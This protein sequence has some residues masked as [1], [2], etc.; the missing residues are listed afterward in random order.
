MREKRKAAQRKERTDEDDELREI[1]DNSGLAVVASFP[2]Q[3]ELTGQRYRA[4]PYRNA[5]DLAYARAARNAFGRPACLRTPFAVSRDLIFL[6]A[7]KRRSV[8]GLYQISWSPLPGRSN[9]QP[10]CDS[11]IRSLGPKSATQAART[12][13]GGSLATSSIGLTVPV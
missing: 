8:T 10:A 9:R 1:E 6:S 5:L 2:S 3:D 4:V 7:G 13:R 12:W 11:K